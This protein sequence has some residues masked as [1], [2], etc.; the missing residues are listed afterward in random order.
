MSIRKLL[1]LLALLLPLILH[2]DT[3]LD[4]FQVNTEPP[5]HPPQDSPYS[6]ADWGTQ[7]IYTTFL[8][9]HDGVNWDVALA[10]HNYDLQPLGQTTYLNVREGQYGCVRPRLALSSQ[11]VGAAWIEARG[12]N[13]L[14]F[15][16]LDAQGNPLGPPVQ[17]ED[18]FADVARDSL[19]IAALTNGYLL[20]WYDA[21]DSSK[22]WAQIVDFAGSLV[23]GNF[24]IQPDSV[25]SILGLEAQNHPDGRVLVSWVTD[26]RYSRGRWLDAEGNFMGEVFEMAEAWINDVIVGSLARFEVDGSGILYQYSGLAVSLPGGPFDWGKYV[27]K[28]HLDAMGL[29]QSGRIPSGYWSSYWEDGPSWGNDNET[30]CDLIFLPNGNLIDIVKYHYQGHVMGGGNWNYQYNILFSS[31]P[32]TAIMPWGLVQNYELCQLNSEDFLYTFNMTYS[33]LRKYQISTL[34]S[35]AQIT[36]IGE[37]GFGAPQGFSDLCVQEDGEFRI[38]YNSYIGN[39]PIVY[40]RYYDASGLALCADTVVSLATNFDPVMSAGGN[41]VSSSDDQTIIVWNFVNEILGTTFSSE[42]W[43]QNVVDFENSPTI[44]LVSIPRFDVNTSGHLL[45]VWDCFFWWGGELPASQ[46]FCQSFENYFSYFLQSVAVSPIC[47]PVWDTIYS[48]VALSDDGKFLICWQQWAYPLDQLMARSG[49]NYDVLS[50]TSTIVSPTDSKPSLEKSSTG[51]WLTWIYS[52][53]TYLAQFDADGN[54]SG[55]SDTISSTGAESLGDP[56]LAVA[57]SSGNFAIVWQDARNDSGDLYCRQFNPDGSFFGREYRVNSDPVGTLQKEPA[58]ALGPNDQLYFTWTDFRNPG[59]QGDIYCKVIEWQDA[60]SVPE[61]SPPAPAKFALKG[62]FPNPFNSTAVISF[63]L[64]AA[65]RVKLEVFDVNG[66]FVGAHGCAPTPGRGST[67]ALQWYAAGAHQITFDGSSLPS[68]VYVYR[69][70]AGELSA[71]GKMVLL[72]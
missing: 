12:P 52:A 1:S 39:Q 24:A 7:T 6:V 42:S 27:Y 43:S 17:V 65:S 68:G 13:R 22:I 10:R 67:P 25:G 11:G 34:D 2:A 72:K 14:Y 29:Q 41:I 59:Q 44:N 40:T 48:D 63:E 57:S 54:F 30:F 49:E 35:S 51:Y 23:G 26:S 60:L 69:L 37:L 32:D 4:D 46:I 18:N 16:S 8:S 70:T 66:R 61:E 55:T 19:S 62:I 31:L 5:G 36:W 50:S 33:G 38:L 53:E 3:L 9:L 56:D 64:P 21:R 58:I 47:W 45:L 28:T 15:R 71:V 20:V